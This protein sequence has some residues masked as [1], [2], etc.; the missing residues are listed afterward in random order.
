MKIYVKIFVVAILFGVFFSFLYYQNLNKDIKTVFNSND[1]E[2]IYVFQ[3]GVFENIENAISL[4]NKYLSG[5][6]Y[7]V[8]DLYH[9]IISATLD[10][11]DLLEDYFKNK[12]INYVIK[13]ELISSDKINKIKEYDK[14]IY[15]SKNAGVIESISKASVALFLSD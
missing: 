14:V 5:G 12:G 2:K 3:V 10:N 4:K 13:E 8:E 1:T 9:V 6:I 7:E 11:K 15:S